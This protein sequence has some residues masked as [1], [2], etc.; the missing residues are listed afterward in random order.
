MLIAINLL[1]PVYA[2]SIVQTKIDYIDVR[3][4]GTFLLTTNSN[5]SASPI[6][7][8]VSNRMSGNANSPGGKIILSAAY[9]AQSTG[10]LVELQGTD[11]CGDYSGIES[12]MRIVISSQ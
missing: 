11:S 7:V 6:C 4:D 5:I 9:V 10:R 3:N 12:I 1:T 8:N 2:G